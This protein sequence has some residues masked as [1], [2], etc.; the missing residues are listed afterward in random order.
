MGFILKWTRTPITWYG[1]KQMMLKYILPAIPEHKL[2]TEPFCGGAA[3]FF[4]KPPAPQEVINDMN[5]EAVNFYR[6]LKADYAP[7]KNAVLTT[8][9]A[10]SAFDDARVI[11]MHPHLFTPVQRAAAFYTFSTQ[12]FSSNLS[13]FAF[14]F[15]GTTVNKV[16]N[17]RDQLAEAMAARLA[18][19]TIERDDALNVIRRYDQ[20]FTF[21]YVDPPYFNS[22]CGPYKG[23]TETDFKELLNTL[24]GVKGKFLLSSYP[25]ELLSAE[26]TRHGW[27]SFAVRKAVAVSGKISKE[28]VEVLTA[29]YP[30][31][32]IL[33]GIK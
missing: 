18:N 10:R 3:V 28:K 32:D 11:Y 16:R 26:T 21:H 6:V 7:L 5:G 31:S 33:A 17:K 27:D 22:N 9:H 20:D 13:S 2:Y 14:D 23:Y 30:I 15:R 29:N 25:S 4:S 1:G 12:S 19:T 8:L 24:S